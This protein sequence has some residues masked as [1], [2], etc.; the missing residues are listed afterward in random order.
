MI[1]EEY[2]GLIVFGVVILALLYFQIF[3]PLVNFIMRFIGRNKN[4]NVMKTRQNVIQT[5]KDMNCSPEEDDGLIHFTFQGLHFLIEAEDEYKNIKIICPWWSGID[6]NDKDVPLL[7]EAINECNLICI[8]PIVYTI[9]KDNNQ[10]GIHCKYNLN[11]QEVNGD[12]ENLLGAYLSSFFNSQREFEN[13]LNRM[14]NEK[15]KDEDRQII[16]GFN[17]NQ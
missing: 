17:Q 5:L 11:F 3:K 13:I 15:H 9:N 1:N 2:I 14:R 8:V 12:Y 10:M 4:M 7:K 6:M 16:K